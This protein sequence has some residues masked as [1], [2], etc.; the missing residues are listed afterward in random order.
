[1]VYADERL[2]VIQ[3]LEC[4]LTRQSDYAESLTRI[5]SNFADS[6]AYY[7][8]RDLDST[9]K[10]ELNQE[11]MVR[12]SDIIEK[13][14]TEFQPKSLV[15]DVGCGSG[16]FL[17]G[18]KRT[19]L[20]TVG[21]EP[22]VS[23]SKYARDILGLEVTTALYDDALFPPDS[24]GVIT[25]IQVLEHV[26]NPL[27][28]LSTAYQHLHSGGY[29]VIDVPGYNNPRFLLYRLTKYKKIVKRDFIPS[30]NFYYTRKTLSQIVELVGFRVI[31][32]LTGRY[33]VKYSNK[34]GLFKYML[35]S[36][37]KLANLL[38]IG[39]ITL[40]ARKE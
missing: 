17:Q 31:E 5:R 6:S 28:T 8:E 22:S 12:T 18:L 37:D 36:L 20:S 26:E 9:G 35:K 11:K 34:H 23:K 39:G 10:I 3:C 13:I 21:V 32:T 40:Y 33:A 7:T 15:L 25:F 24:F 38:G 1:M 27:E 19:G 16:E 4:G 30:H 2:V 14:V 29:L